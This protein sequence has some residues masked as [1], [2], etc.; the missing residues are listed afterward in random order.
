[1]NEIAEL[2]RQIDREK[3]ERARAMSLTEKFRAGAELFEEACEVA[4]CG[5]RSMHPDWVEAQVEAELARR[6]QIG[7][8]SKEAALAQ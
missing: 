4:R 2:A 7:R 6:L 5:I 3:I 8:R 1:M